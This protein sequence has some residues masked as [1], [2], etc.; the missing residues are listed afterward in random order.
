MLLGSLLENFI[1]YI[2]PMFYFT[3]TLS[4]IFR[5][6]AEEKREPKLVPECES[7]E[8]CAETEENMGAIA[9]SEQESAE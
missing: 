9:E 1:F 6:A 8:K 4:V 5:L 3:V 2:H 7:V